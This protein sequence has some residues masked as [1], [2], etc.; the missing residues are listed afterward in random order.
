MP[1]GH[2]RVTVGVP[3]FNGESFIAETLDSLLNQTFCDFEIVISDNASTDRTG[4]VCRTYA[5]RDSRIRY[6]RSDVNRGAAWNH[7]RVFELARGE[8]FKWNSADDLCGP[9]FLARCVAALESDPTAVVAMTEAVQIDERG[10]PF[11]SIDAWGQT[12]SPLVPPT[13]PPHVRFRQNIRMNHLCVTVYGLMRSS[14]LRRTDLIGSYPDGDRNLLAHLALFGRC[15]NISEVL[16]FNRDHAGRFGRVYERD[17]H[18]GWREW[19]TWFDPSKTGRKVFPFCK[20]CVE[21]WRMIGRSSLSTKERLRCRLILIQWLF[22]KDNLG[23][24]YQDATYYPRKYIARRFPRVKLAW[25]WL[26]GR[27]NVLGPSRTP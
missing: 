8:F 15:L 5:G 2:P 21:L 3:V 25:N 23:R 17:Y 10:E 13:A 1:E 22:E 19:M 6:Y 16:F 18:C 9:E 24:F 27:R 11:G 7:N 20:K 4:E 26:W 14:V 12:L